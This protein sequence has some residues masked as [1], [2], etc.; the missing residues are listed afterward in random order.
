[1]WLSNRGIHTHSSSPQSELSRVVSSFAFPSRTWGEESIFRKISSTLESAHSI[2]ESFKI[3]C[4]EESSHHLQSCDVTNLYPPSSSGPTLEF[5]HKLPLQNLKQWQKRYFC[6]LFIQAQ[7][8]HLCNAL[9]YS[10]ESSF[11]THTQSSRLVKVSW[12]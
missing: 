10:L 4:T 2:F 8:W 3:L 1:M 11:Q 9:I 6:F 12:R 5:I 7:L